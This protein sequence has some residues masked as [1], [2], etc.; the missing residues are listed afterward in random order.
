MADA[1]ETANERRQRLKFKK[2]AFHGIDIDKI[3]ALT[4]DELA[5]L[6]KARAR[7]NFNRGMQKTTTTLMK[8]LRKS[9]KEAPFGEKPTAVKTHLRSI[10][11]VPEMIGG[12]IGVH[13]GKT[14]IQVEIKP[15]MI[16]HKLSEF[17]LSYKQVTH[18]RPGI[19]ATSSSKF[20]PLK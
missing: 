3:L 9:K 19:G 1:N 17:S 11:I 15:D 18:G 7:R 13:N 10:V 16:G 2:F 5:Q 4:D 6:Y 12:V 8:K 20:V 14:Y